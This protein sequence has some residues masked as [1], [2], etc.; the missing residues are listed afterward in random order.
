MDI[1]IRNIETKYICDLDKKAKL[2]S[3]KL[4]KKVSRNEY[5]KRLIEA[6]YELSSYQEKEDR[7]DRTIASTILA[8]ER[9]ES[10]IQDNNNLMIRVL[11]ALLGEEKK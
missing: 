1:K 5:V 9:L 10:R 4:G 7:F 8:I 11:Y 2:L 6:E 3:N